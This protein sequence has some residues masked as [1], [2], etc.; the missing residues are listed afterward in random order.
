M[1]LGV[2]QP[3]GHCF[4]RGTTPRKN[5][6]AAT[7]NPTEV[8]TSASCPATRQSSSNNSSDRG[9]CSVEL[10]HPPQLS[11]VSSVRTSTHAVQALVTS[12]LIV[13]IS[14][15]YT[16]LSAT[17]S[18][19]HLPHLPDPSCPPL[20]LQPVTCGYLKATP[21]L[22]RL[23]IS[24]VGTNPDEPTITTKRASEWKVHVVV[25]SPRGR[26]QLL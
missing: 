20:R 22:Q 17:A 2:A 6:N 10:P 12:G 23:K 5:R 19:L 7:R 16:R 18:H 8:S 24:E 1:G 26:L 11:P 13:P 3:P 25:D 15:T 4:K 21:P 14:I 9:Y